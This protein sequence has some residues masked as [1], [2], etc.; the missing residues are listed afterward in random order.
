MPGAQRPPHLRYLATGNSARDLDLLRQAVG[1]AKLSYL[2]YSYRWAETL[3]RHLV[4]A[5]LLAMR[6]D[7]Y[8]AFTGN[9]ARIDAAV[10]AQ[11]DDNTF[12][13]AGT[14]CDRELPFTAPSAEPGTARSTRETTEA[15]L[16]RLLPR[17]KRLGEPP[18]RRGAAGRDVRS[19]GA[20]SS[21]LLGEAPAGG[22][23]RRPAAR[24]DPGALA[25]RF[26]T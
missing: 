23:A 21:S 4:K 9:P 12:P 15:I 13:A 18:G 25:T 6:G 19:P 10:E 16:D 14:I 11:L 5:R 2:G 24:Y 8:A 3:T 7:G 20:T 1:D 26:P 22:S 17:I